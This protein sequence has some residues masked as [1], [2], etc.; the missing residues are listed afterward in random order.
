MP[1]FDLSLIHDCVATI[2]I[3]K[4]RYIFPVPSAALNL[5]QKS[6]IKQNKLKNIRL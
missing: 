3:Q 2:D 1:L 4:V 6:E 5:H